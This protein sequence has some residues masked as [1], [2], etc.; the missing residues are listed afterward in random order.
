MPN[1]TWFETNEDLLMPL[2]LTREEAEEDVTEAL[3]TEESMDETARGRFPGITLPNQTNV[4]VIPIIPGMT[5]LG[6]VRFFNA[7]PGEPRVDIYVNGRRVAENLLYRAFTEFM[8]ALPGWYRVAVYAAGTRKK[9]L[10]VTL[11][12]V[13]PNRIVTLAVKGLAGEIET[14]AIMDSRRTLSPTRPSL[15]FVQLSPNAPEMDAYWDDA[16]VLAD[17]EYG[18]VS[19]YLATRAGTHNL[20]MRDSLSGANLVEHPDV[21]LENGKAYTAYIVGDRND[22]TGLQILLPLEGAGYLA[23]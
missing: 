11:M 15:R 21:Q 16:L 23:F 10:T 19:R 5:L 1:R 4:T 2:P 8:K 12:Q 3:L 6:Y 9:P 20:K 7:S 14:Q 18:D 13:L 17:L 22:R